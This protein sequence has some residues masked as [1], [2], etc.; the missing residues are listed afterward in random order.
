MCSVKAV[1]LDQSEWR[2]LQMQYF[3]MVSLCKSNIAIPSNI[4][5]GFVKQCNSFPL[6]LQREGDAW[7]GPHVLPP[8]RP[9]VMLFVDPYRIFSLKG[10]NIIYHVFM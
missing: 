2:V 5:S 10:S 4:R 6:I 3:L 7:H 9:F 1:F 8:A